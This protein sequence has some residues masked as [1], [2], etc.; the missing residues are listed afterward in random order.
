MPGITIVASG[1][2]QA[3][4]FLFL[5]VTLIALNSVNV[6]GRKGADNQDS[7]LGSSGEVTPSLVYKS[8]MNKYFNKNIVP[9]L[10]FV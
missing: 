9:K 4:T 1:A 6:A 2:R 5:N 3:K 8:L 10:L 7:L